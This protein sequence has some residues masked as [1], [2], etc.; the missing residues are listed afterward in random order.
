[1]ALITCSTDDKI[2]LTIMQIMF[3][4]IN[5]YLYKAMITTY[6]N[7]FTTAASLRALNIL[8]LT[9]SKLNFFSLQLTQTND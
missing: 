4:S 7:H 2:Q 3:C 5:R 9:L 1:M 6:I 8:P